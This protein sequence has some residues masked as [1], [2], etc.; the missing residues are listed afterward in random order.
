V[1]LLK[2]I[3]MKQ[4]D[5][6]VAGVAFGV[7]L[8]AAIACPQAQGIITGQ[9]TSLRAHSG[10]ASAGDSSRNC[11]V[12]QIGGSDTIGPGTQTTGPTGKYAIDR[13][14]PGYTDEKEALEIAFAGAAG[15]Q[16]Q[17]QFYDSGTTDPNCGGT[18]YVTFRCCQSRVAMKRRALA[19]MIGLLAKIRPE[20]P[21]TSLAPKGLEPKREPC[22]R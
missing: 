12:F 8:F 3:T 19:G 11:M 2:G 17:L 4:L 16:V 1:K 15:N 20:P 10:N 6:V 21:K 9:I 18:E 5:A 22:R 14:D 13:A 7:T